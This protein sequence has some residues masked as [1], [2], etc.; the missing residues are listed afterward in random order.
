MKLAA[1]VTIASNAAAASSPSLKHAGHCHVDRDRV[2]MTPRA[3]TS[4]YRGDILHRRVVNDW[5]KHDPVVEDDPKAVVCRLIGVEMSHEIFPD[6]S[7]R[8]EVSRD[9]YFV[10]AG[11]V[12]LGLTV[13]MTTP[14]GQR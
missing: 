10:R 2:A 1:G 8:T 4:Y 12:T 3:E 14:S 11:G 9:E 6:L 5:Q 13:T 7:A